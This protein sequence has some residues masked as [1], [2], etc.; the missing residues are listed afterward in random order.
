MQKSLKFFCVKYELFIL[1]IIFRSQDSQSHEIN[2][3]AILTEEVNIEKDMNY[4][5]SNN[6]KRPSTMTT[7][8]STSKSLR[9]C[10]PLLPNPPSA[11]NIDDLFIKEIEAFKVLLLLFFETNP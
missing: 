10:P 7:E 3:L 8:G 5:M 2:Q 4:I 9:P 11:L 6:L 1:I